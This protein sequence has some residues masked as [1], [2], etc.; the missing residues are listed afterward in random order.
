MA[1][2]TKVVANVYRDSVSLMQISA[3]LTKLPGIKQASA[4]MASPSNIALLR[5]AGL[6]RGNVEAGPND[7]I[8]VI[9]GAGETEVAEAM[10]AAHR[11]LEAQPT[12]AS[13]AT[14]GAIT[15]GAITPGVM[16]PRSLA[17]A[18][19]VQPRAKL[20]LIST[21]G[22]YAAA[23]A[24]KA[25]RLGLHVM[26]FSDNVPV[27]DEI[28]LKLLARQRGLLVM[29]P[30]CGTAIINGVPLAFANA[31]RRGAIGCVA[32]SGTGLQQV[33]CLVDRLGAGISQ[34]IGTG[35]HDLSED[36][37]GLSMLQGIEALAADAD[38]KVI[39]LIS[40]PPSPKVAAHVLATAS[41]AGKP[42][43][44]NF[45]GADPDTIK[46]P[47][48]HPVTTLE[49][50][51][52]AAVALQSGRR[53]PA[54]AESKPV[55]ALPKLGKGRPYIRGLFSGGTFCYESSLLLGKTLGNVRS[56]APVDP[57]DRLDDVWTA[58]G[59][60]VIDLGDDVFTRGRPHPMI[61]HRLR[62]ERLLKEA[63][64]PQVG[65]ILFDVVLGYG[66]HPDPAAEMAP[67]LRE[68]RDKAPDIA[69][70][71]FV[72]GTERD[73]Q[74][75]LQQEARL[76]EEGVLLADCNAAAVRLAAAIVNGGGR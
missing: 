7:L 1:S 59:H 37:G 43:V 38:T 18:L 21:P 75:L 54:S 12:A 61:D 46:L 41:R 69:F 28:A 53:P 10:E 42:V 29:G 11:A 49:E 51:A 5:E 56:N 16:A 67:V 58:R 3:A 70:V 47:N 35:G 6:L 72:C 24:E 33:T 66:S 26:V 20:A 27:A 17:M 71:G 73:P 68:A 8:I 14:T 52:L 2:A 4:V 36:V 40:K 30:D 45:L 31:V 48:L 25:L 60:T 57:R 65:L 62:N 13:G 64:D 50:A 44:V 9:A 23:E 74:G 55:A 39:V 63:S 76:R 19:A 15:P 34:A 32:A 22:E